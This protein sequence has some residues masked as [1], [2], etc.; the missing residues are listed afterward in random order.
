MNTAPGRSLACAALTALLFSPVAAL[1]APK[2]VPPG[3]ARA[4]K[5]QV[6]KKYLDGPWLVPTVHSLRSADEWNRQMSEWLLDQKVVGRES[7]PDVDWSH[8]AV[9][10]L[11][12]GRQ[13]GNCSMTVNNCTVAGDTTVLDVHL[14]TPTQ[15]DPYGDVVHPAVLVTVE[16]SDLKNLEIRCDSVI[17]GLPN[18]AGR[19]GGNG[20][21]LS[22]EPVSG[23]ANVTTTLG[24]ATTWGRVKDA[25]RR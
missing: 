11:S 22:F 13:I 16:R 15:W 8:Q 3:H 21:G 12:L 14:E 4:A 20:A 17:D 25:Y 7:A 2:P 6:F 10:V 1:S 24:A 19:R 5:F 23:D 9:V 18:S